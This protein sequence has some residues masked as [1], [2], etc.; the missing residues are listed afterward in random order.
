MGDRL[1]IEA[2]ALTSAGTLPSDA[3]EYCAITA[4]GFQT[5][6]LSN[7][8]LCGSRGRGIPLLGC[9]IRLKP[10]AA[11]KYQC[12]YTCHFVSGKIL[13]P[14]G[15]GDLCCSETP[16]DPLWGI[17]LQLTERKPSTATEPGGETQ[18]VEVAQL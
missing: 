8:M 16:M 12:T 9:A 18:L 17:E 13:G 2:F 4:D 5:P 6:W 3:V 1:W 14:I 15:N 11:E 7:R 10:E